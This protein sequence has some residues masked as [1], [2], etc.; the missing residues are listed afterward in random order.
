MDSSWGN[1]LR[2]FTV[3][4]AKQILKV[5]PNKFSPKIGDLIFVFCGQKYARTVTARCNI[6]QNV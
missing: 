1:Q 2:N 5:G 4:W 3:Y 6:T